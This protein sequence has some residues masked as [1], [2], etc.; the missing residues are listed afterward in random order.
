MWTPIVY[1]YGCAYHNQRI[2]SEIL[3]LFCRF[4]CCFH[5]SLFVLVKLEFSFFSFCEWVV[6]VTLS[7]RSMQ[8]NFSWFNS[9]MFW[10]SFVI[11]SVFIS[12]LEHTYRTRNNHI[13]QQTNDKTFIIRNW[14]NWGAFDKCVTNLLIFFC[15]FVSAVFLFRF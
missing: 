10:L 13:L 15:S 5:F 9:R 7:K 8:A 12:I 1:L 14:I 3:L 2:Q 6:C 4:L 11:A